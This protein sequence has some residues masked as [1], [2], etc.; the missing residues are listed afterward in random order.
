MCDPRQCRAKSLRVPRTSVPSGND[1]VGM[2]LYRG[3]QYPVEVLGPLGQRI[4]D[5]ENRLANKADKL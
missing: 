4:G 2:A 5:P 1:S 3:L